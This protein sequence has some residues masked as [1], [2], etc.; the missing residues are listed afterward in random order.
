MARFVLIGFGRESILSFSFFLV[1]QGFKLQVQRV[2]CGGIYLKYEKKKLEFDREKIHGQNYIHDLLGSQIS[3]ILSIAY[4]APGLIMHDCG[5]LHTRGPLTLQLV[6]QRQ[7]FGSNG[8][9]GP[10]K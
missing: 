7:G 2:H 1:L 9:C 4:A 8:R 5:M 3:F 6:D 10:L